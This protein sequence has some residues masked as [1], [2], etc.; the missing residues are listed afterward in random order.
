MGY[1]AIYLILTV[2]EAE[3]LE[4]ECCP[5]NVLVNLYSRSHMFDFLCSLV[6]EQ[7]WER[8]YFCINIFGN[9]ISTLASPLSII[10]VCKDLNMNLRRTKAFN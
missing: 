3:S 5:G 7:R 9:K 6:M 10:R 4:S 8:L 1:V 2:L